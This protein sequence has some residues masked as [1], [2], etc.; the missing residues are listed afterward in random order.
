MNI[1][2]LAAGQGKRMNSALPKVLH[3]LGGKALLAH[4]LTAARHLQPQR[5][6][7][8]HGHG[9]EVVRAALDAP[10]LVWALQEPQLGTGHAVQQA[11]PALDASAAATL[12]LYG[13]V[14]LIKVETLSSLV[15]AAG[16]GMALL[17]AELADPTGYGR[18]VRDA[19]GTVQRIVEQKDADAREQAIREINTGIMV[20]PTAHLAAWLGALSNNNAQGEYYLTDLVAQAVAH[21]VA[22]RTVTVGDVWETAGVNSK[23]QL[24]EL[25]RVLQRRIA[26]SLMA[27]GVRLAD[28]ARLD[29]RGDLRCGRDVFIDVNCVFEGDVVLGEGVEIGPNCVVKDAQIGAGTKVA[30]FSHLDRATVGC[31]AAIGPYARLRPGSE[32]GNDVHIGNFV[33]IKNT[34]IADHSKA[35]HLAYVGDAIIGQRVNIGAGTITCNYD[36]VNKH[37][38]IIEDD[39]FIG[40]DTQLVAP[41]TVG[42]GATL[43]AGT[44]LTHDAPAEALTLSRVRQTTLSG[45]K[46]PQKKSVK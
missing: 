12:V 21:G 32:L 46:R 33:E 13:D 9:G 19:H 30:A 26:D 6:C 17:T 28:P 43:G 3:P 23:T 35:N 37:Q 34:R 18:I 24:A 5:L 15:A 10:D 4:V 8:V 1:V 42:R 22:V 36:G 40:S 2:I 25:E 45:W 16:D 11:L 39:A 31:A 20:L 38:T 44:T 7:V 14:P 29:V 27:E 41:V